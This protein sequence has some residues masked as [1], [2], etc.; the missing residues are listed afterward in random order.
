LVVIK[1]PLVVANAIGV[2]VAEGAK[3]DTLTDAHKAT[4]PVVVPITNCTVPEAPVVVT[5]AGATYLIPVTIAPLGII[6]PALITVLAL[7][8]GRVKL[9][10]AVLLILYSL[11]TVAA[12]LLYYIL[13]YKLKRYVVEVIY[14]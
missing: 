9:A 7:L 3:A 1:L 10:K 6:A 8:F 14:R 12:I 11:Y 2:G 13:Y 4:D 5:A